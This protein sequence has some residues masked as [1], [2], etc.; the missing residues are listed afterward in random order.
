MRGGGTVEDVQLVPGWLAYMVVEPGERCRRWCGGV[1]FYLEEQARLDD[2][3]A[4]T[5]GMNPEG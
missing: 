1:G 3:G 2:A 5:A 4:G